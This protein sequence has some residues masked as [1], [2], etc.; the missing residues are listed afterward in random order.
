MSNTR[1]GLISATFLMVLIAWT[2]VCIGNVDLPSPEVTVTEGNGMVKITWK[3]AR[4]EDLVLINQPELGTTQFEW[5]GNA[6]SIR[7][8]GR[9]TGACDWKYDLLVAIIADTVEF[10]WTGISDWTKMTPEPKNVQ[11]TELD[12]AYDISDGIQLVIRSDGLFDLDKVGWEG[13]EPVL[14]GIYTGGNPLQP[15]VPVTFSFTCGLGGQLGAGD[16]L[17]FVWSNST[18]G[19]GSFTVKEADGSFEI[20]KGFRVGFPPGDY[21]QGQQFSVDVYIPF[22]STDRLGIKAETF[23]GYL[24]LRHSF[25][26]RPPD[27]PHEGIGQYKVIARI[28]KC[29]TFEFFI[30]PDT[31]LPDPGGEREHMDIGVD[32][33]QPGVRPDPGFRTVTN[34]FAYDYAVVTYDWTSTEEQAISD[35]IHWHQV[36]PSVPPAISASGISVIPNPFIREA[37]GGK[38]QVQF[39]NLPL[40]SVVRIYDATGSFV[41]TV[42][43]EEYSYGGQQGRAEWDL[44]NGDGDDITSGIYIYLVESGSGTKTGRFVVVR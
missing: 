26:D 21:I 7:A 11:I 5:K 4:W 31:G 12:H 13:P 22:V 29:D 39:M 33:Q 42:Y 15:E 27:G 10:S 37:F 28:S 2:G 25:E 16:S 35:S 19:A 43:P 38:P 1:S 8:Q 24:V 23:D 3:D 36:V 6:D 9:Y 30:D 32:W 14:G 18:G 44:R 20:E 34:G 17:V 41:A 40:G